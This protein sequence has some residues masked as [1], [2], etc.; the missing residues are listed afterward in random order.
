MFLY[1]I[2][3]HMNMENYWRNYKKLPLRVKL[4]LGGVRWGVLALNYMYMYS[5]FSLRRKIVET[6]EILGS[7]YLF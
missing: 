5:F 6:Q 3:V 7:R 1:G 2:K 4:G